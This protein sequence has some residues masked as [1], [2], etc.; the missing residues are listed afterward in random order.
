MLAVALVGHADANTQEP[1]KGGSR[2]AATLVVG[3]NDANMYVPVNT[4]T[5]RVK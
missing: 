3:H 5:S 1:I 2:L 4:R